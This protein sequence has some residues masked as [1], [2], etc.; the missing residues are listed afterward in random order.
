MLYDYKVLKMCCDKLTEAFK[1]KDIGAVAGLEARY[2]SDHV[3]FFSKKTEKSKELGSW[4]FSLL[5]QRFLV[6][7]V[8]CHGFGRWFHS[9]AQAGQVARKYY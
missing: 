1:D 5:L 4:L 2:V 3:A 9:A 7:S 8:G 6:W